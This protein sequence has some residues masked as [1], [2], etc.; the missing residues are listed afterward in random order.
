MKKISY[1]LLVVLLSLSASAQPGLDQFLQQVVNNN[2][3]YRARLSLADA[4]QLENRLGNTPAN[5]Q[6]EGGYLWGS[7]SSIGHRKDFSVSQEIEFPTVYLH[8]RKL[9]DL[10]ER[11]AGMSTDQYALAVQQEAA[12]LWVELVSL[13]RQIKVYDE[14]QQQARELAAA[15]DDRL[16][17]GDANRI[18]R[19][20]AALN[21]LQT[22]KQRMRFVQQRELLQLSLSALNG[23]LPVTVGENEFT[24]VVLP[25][26][27]ESWLSA[28][29]A[30][31]PQSQW[32]LL[33]QE[34]AERQ[35]KLNQAKSLPTISGG[36]ML[37]NTVGEKF[38]GIT[39]GLSVPLWENKN[40]VKA[41][42]LRQEA[43]QLE[44]ADFQLQFK[45]QLVRLYR[46]V[47]LSSEQVEGFRDELAEIKQKELLDDALAAGQ[48]SLIEYLLELQF[49]YNATDQLMEAEKELQLAWV[50]LKVLGNL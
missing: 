48:I 50:K 37:E 47:L 15:Y 13:N 32:Y 12:Q 35:V 42:R 44:Q 26:D 3:A 8:Q 39:L 17:A 24:A 31:S 23:N 30:Q 1:S 33:Q 11:Q 4:Q 5:P 19:N 34:V 41:A 21:A 6:L 10:R 16:A 45:S 49:N 2:T 40:A 46:E 22:E 18:D 27:F 20:K 9:A 29:I 38:H 7:P 25:A 43:G 14:R 36:Y 28:Q